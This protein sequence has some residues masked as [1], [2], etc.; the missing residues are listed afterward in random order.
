MQSTEDL[1]TLNLKLWEQ[2]HALELKIRLESSHRKREEKQFRKKL[3]RLSK[4]LA[5]TGSTPKK[6]RSALQNAC[7]ESLNASSCTESNR[8]QDEDGSSSSD[9][10]EDEQHA[11]MVAESFKS[12]LAKA[13]K[14]KPRSGSKPKGG[15]SPEQDDT[16]S[17]TDFES[18]S[19]VAKSNHGRRVV[20][21]LSSNGRKR[22]IRQSNYLEEHLTLGELAGLIPSS[23]LLNVD[24]EKF[25]VENG[26]E[27]VDQ[28]QSL[29]KDKSPSAAKQE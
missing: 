23:L 3:V 28:T 25:S 2:V 26:F 27:P 12:Q 19:L 4:Y 21:G 18:L 7:Q 15:E 1:R 8:L 13:E 5:L 29:Q 20:S 6:L 16:E 24:F 10:R 11:K 22:R 17:D 9:E 14:R